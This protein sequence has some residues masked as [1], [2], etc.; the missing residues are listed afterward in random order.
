MQPDATGSR[1]LPH[2]ATA[3]P[4]AAPV[5]PSAAP[6]GQD[7]PDECSDSAR[8][9]RAVLG[10]A[11]E[12]P[13]VVHVAELPDAAAAYPGL[14]EERVEVPRAF[15][16]QHAADAGGQVA[17]GIELGRAGVGHELQRGYPRSPAVTG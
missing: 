12:G 11:A 4:S 7:G 16:R 17:A 9:H 3:G 10:V 5:G 15:G 8:P 6:V 13:A 14:G 1:Y 2:Y